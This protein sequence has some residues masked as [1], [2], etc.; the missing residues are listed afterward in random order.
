M[1]LF[2]EL[3]SYGLLAIRKD[4]TIFNF[5]N[6]LKT[7]DAGRMMTESCIPNQLY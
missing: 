1:C 2:Q 7:M 5:S 6:N 4:K 3:D